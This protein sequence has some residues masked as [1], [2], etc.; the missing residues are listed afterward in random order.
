MRIRSAVSAALVLA[1]L[2]LVSACGG[3]PAPTAASVVR[4]TL[5]RFVVAEFNDDGAIMCSLMTTSAQ[6][7]VVEAERLNKVH[8]ATCAA[9]LTASLKNA[10]ETVADRKSFKSFKSSIAVAPVLIRGNTAT[11]TLAKAGFKPVLVRTHGR[12]LFSSSGQVR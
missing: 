10:F 1:A 4:A 6:Q 11:V 8:Y 12:W 5:T 3:T 2:L 9:A 7:G